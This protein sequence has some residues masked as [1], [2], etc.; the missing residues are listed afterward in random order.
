L[1]VFQVGENSFNQEFY[2]YEIENLTYPIFSYY[3]KKEDIFVYIDGFLTIE[4]V[5]NTKILYDSDIDF[6]RLNI[7]QIAHT[8]EPDNGGIFVGTGKDNFGKIYKV[9]WEN[10]ERTKFIANDIF[11]FI[12][13]LQYNRNPIRGIELNTLYKNWDEDFW[14][15]RE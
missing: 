14:R 9:A 8:H 2:Y 11:E 1:D 10:D 6:S 13:S 3:L 4:E 5:I 12:K 7:I 15:L